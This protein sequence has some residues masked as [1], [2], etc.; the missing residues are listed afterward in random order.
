VKQG[1]RER[2]WLL[3]LH[4]IPSKPGYL[5]VKVWRRLQRI[6][7]V[8]VKNGVYA[9]PLSEEHNE[10]LRWIMEAVHSGGGEATLIE[11]AFVQGLTDQEV[12]G[13]FNKAR[14]AEYAELAKRIR[15]V[16]KRLPAR[17]KVSEEKRRALDV[18]LK[19]LREAYGVLEKIDFFSSSGREVTRGLL[20]ELDGRV[21]ALSDS[22]KKVRAVR[23][24]RESYRARTWVT[25]KGIHVDRMASAWL[26]RRFIDQEAHFKWVAPKGYEPEAGELRFDMFEAEFTHVGDACTFEVLLERAALSDK[27]LQSIAEIVHDIDIKDEKYGRP[28][29]AG[30]ASVVAGIALASHDDDERLARAS[31]LFDQL[32]GV[33]SR[34]RT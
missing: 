8:A 29:V 2:R 4:Q 19:D 30:V 27:A 16:T 15:A 17:G 21:R 34:R 10:D 14:D 32:Y 25:R 18:E 3:L 33:F 23:P 22:D 28:E 20:E 31:V 26:I 9:L 11:A 24:P 5:R 7:A 6:G 13:L 1:V 12:E